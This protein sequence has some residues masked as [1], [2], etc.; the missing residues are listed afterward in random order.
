[1]LAALLLRSG[2]VVPVEELIDAVWGDDPPASAAHSL[3]AYVSRLRQALPP[4]DVTLER[5][6]RGYRLAV[7]DTQLDRARFESLLEQAVSAST[8]GAHSRAAELASDALRL[9]TGTP[10]AGLPLHGAARAEVERLEELRLAG[11]ETR[12]E[13]DLA[14]GRH[15]QLV[16][17]LRP[18][19]EANLYRERLVSQ[20]ML[21]L[22][23]SGRQAEAVA[24][25]ERARRALDN[26]LGLQP[27]ED[28]QRL[29][30]EI[31]RQEAQLAVPG[32]TPKPPSE[33]SSRPRRRRGL[34]TLLAAVIAIGAIT[35][36]T[37]WVVVGGGG[38]AAVGGSTRVALVLAKGPVAGRGD[39]SESPFVDGLL[40]ADRE[41]ELDTKILILSP[42]PKSVLRVAK[43][44][45]TGHYDL[46]LATSDLEATL[47][48]EVQ[49][50]PATKFA[51]I[52]AALRGTSLA[53][54]ANATGLPFED[55][56]AGVLAGYL[57]GL[58]VSEAAKRH[59]HRPI[60][61]VVGGGRVPAVAALV[62]GFARGAHKASSRIVVRV[63]YSNTFDAQPSCE[64]IANRQ[65]DHG[66]TLVYAPAGDCGFGGLSAAALRGVWGVGADADLSYLG[67][68]ILAST[69]KRYDRAVLFAVRWFVEGSLPRGR[70]VPL[71][72]DD[73]AVGIAGISPEVS[74]RIR[75]KVAR[76]AAALRRAEGTA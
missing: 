31:V 24:A 55:V 46:V 42:F 64:A 47:S 71:G 43:Q 76:L 72:I 21:A 12:I 1:M 15:A 41:Y 29:S 51:F 18:L 25:Y 67:S 14:L 20:L 19:V 32:K 49:D 62:Q 8:A 73:E 52:D 16:A 53:G 66:S 2:E 59:G 63:E 68:H 27:S 40:R 7:A 56:E 69:V 34:P 6:G 70:D 57:S 37:A 13:A 35:F 9:W 28:L 38:S 11:L 36:G 44:L 45:R 10:L 58:V 5:I 39:T 30:G 50:L 4:G 54:S 33:A 60:V 65:I 74:P 22:Y 3:Q 48:P 75:R 23:R 17:E 61:S 26:D